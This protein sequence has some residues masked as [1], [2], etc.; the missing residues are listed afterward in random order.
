MSE[1]KYFKNFQEYRNYHIGDKKKL[2]IDSY[3]LINPIR[4]NIQQSLV[5][6]LT[7]NTAYFLSNFEVLKDNEVL[8][9]NQYSIKKIV[10]NGCE[11]KNKRTVR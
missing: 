9:K 1:I 8:P 3:T 2:E 10:Y 7:N 11:Q 4:D 6:T 5:F